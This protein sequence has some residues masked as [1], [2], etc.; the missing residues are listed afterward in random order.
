MEEYI[1]RLKKGDDLYESIQNFCIKNN[2]L[3]GVV[4]SGVGSLLSAH[5]RDASGVNTQDINEPTEIVSL[6]GT[7]SKNRLHL[8]ISL[9][10]TDISVVGGHLMTGCK[11][12]T[13]CEVAILEFKNYEFSKEFDATTGYNELKIIKK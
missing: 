7:V 12:N 5:I 8:H 1:F 2:I 10:K 3:A 9:A 11:I 13:T 4:V 6:N